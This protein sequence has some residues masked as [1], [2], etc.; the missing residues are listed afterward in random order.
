MDN[1]WKIYISFQK[2]LINRIESQEILA[3][4]DCF[5]IEKNDWERFIYYKINPYDQNNNNFLNIQKEIPEF[6]DN[7]SSALTI[8]KNNKNIK[9]VKK[10]LIESL[11]QDN[12]LKDFKSINYYCGNKKLLIEFNEKY[13]CMALLILNP[14]ESIVNNNANLYIIAFRTMNHLKETIYKNL[15]SQEIDLNIDILNNLKYN[16]I[17]IKKLNNYNNINGIYPIEEH[18]KNNGCNYF[19]DDN[20][21]IIFIYIF[22]YEKYLSIYKEN[23]FDENNSYFLINPEWLKYYKDFYNY[24]KLFEVLKN[25]SNNDNNNLIN[26]TN[27]GRFNL[28]ILN[29]LNNFFFEK[30]KTDISFGTIMPNISY[31]NKNI[32]FYDNCFIIDEQI[33]NRML[34]AHKNLTDNIDKLSYKIKVKSKYIYLICYNSNSVSIGFLNDNLLFTPTLLFL[35]NNFIILERE[36]NLLFKK[37]IKEYIQFRKCLETYKNIQALIERK[38]NKIGNMISLKVDEF[39]S[40]QITDNMKKELEKD[41]NKNKEISEY[42]SILSNYTNNSLKKKHF[43]NL[44]VGIIQIL[45]V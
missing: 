16:N 28:N 37:T 9:L 44:K 40:K 35:Y 36:F 45:E 18:Q 8:L 41:C 38:N 24:K 4:D 32:N 5:L 3:R 29:D 2:E 43:T 26:Y 27:L 23:I 1:L 12:N 11:Y 7:I 30:R 14:L 19:K 39:K 13:S 21:L 6:I 15:L 42:K 33:I 10:D 31:I 20:I 34:N 17:I 22:Y 25:I